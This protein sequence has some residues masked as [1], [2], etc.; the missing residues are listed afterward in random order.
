[1]SGDNHG[2]L[3]LTREHDDGT[4]IDMDVNEVLRLERLHNGFLWFLVETHKRDCETHVG[5]GCNLIEIVRAIEKQAEMLA[6]DEIRRL[7]DRLLR[8]EACGDCHLST[9]PKRDADDWDKRHV[10]YRVDG[11]DE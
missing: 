1:M 10:L 9:C 8:I 11:G 3:V 7:R 4:R 6:F 2:R 5:A